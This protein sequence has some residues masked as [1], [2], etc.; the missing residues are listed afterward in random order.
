MIGEDAHAGTEWSTESMELYGTAQP[1][2]LPQKNP[3]IMC[4]RNQLIDAT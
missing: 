1:L 2:H 3:Y 4:E